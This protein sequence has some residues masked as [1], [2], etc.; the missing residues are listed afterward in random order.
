MAGGGT[1]VAHAQWTGVVRVAHPNKQTT[2]TSTSEHH[3][4]FS[5]T[6][7]HRNM[8]GRP[9]ARSARSSADP[10]PRKSSTRTPKARGSASARTSAA[11]VEIPEEGPVTSLRTQICSIFADAQRTTATQ[12]KLIVTL[13]KVQEACCYEPTNPKKKRAGEEF[14]EEEFNE[15]IGRCVLRVFAVKKSEAVGDRIVRFL[16]LFLKFA[17][18]KG[19]WFI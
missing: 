2:S 18:E 4:S 14:G 12:R 15:E 9:A 17:S 6:T 11:A 10:A 1:S 16:G 7:P 13:R 5:S 3:H 8:P 19:E